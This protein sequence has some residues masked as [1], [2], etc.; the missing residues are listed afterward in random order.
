MNTKLVLPLV[1]VYGLILIGSLVGIYYL[2]GKAVLI[3]VFQV[4]ANPFSV[5]G[6][7]A[8][9]GLVVILVS[10]ISARLFRSI[11]ELED[12]FRAILGRLSIFDV[13]VIALVSSLAEEVLFRGLLQPFVGLTIASLIFGLLHFPIKQTLLPW[14]VFAIVMG[15]LLGWLYIYTGSLVT[16]I[17]THCLINL[18]NIW[19]IT[20]KDR[21]H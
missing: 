6:W 12:E 8:I 9:S 13:V 18:V 11:K 2:Q 14:T 7:G 15:F 1:L 10:I 16:P 3:K 21:N 20:A 19:R 5:I 4:S 17:I